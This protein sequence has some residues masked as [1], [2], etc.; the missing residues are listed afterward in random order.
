MHSGISRADTNPFS[1]SGS[2]MANQQLN[3]MNTGSNPFF[4]TRFSQNSSTTPL[5]F[6]NDKPQQVT[7]TATGSNPFKVS[8]TTTN[9]FNNVSNGPQPQLKPQPTAGGLENLPTVPVFPDTQQESQ[10]QYYLNNARMELQQQMTNN[11][12]FPQ[13]PSQQ[14]PQQQQWNQPH[15]FQQMQPQYTQNYQ[16]PQQASMYNNTYEGPSLI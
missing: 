10:K 2:S 12:Q 11:Q 16:Q 1:N 15:Q 13:Q 9:L 5:S 8:E 7:S 6:A 3:S 4:N 14:Q